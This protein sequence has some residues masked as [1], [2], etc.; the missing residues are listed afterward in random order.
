MN[1]IEQLFHSDSE[2]R[3]FARGYLAYLS[4]VLSRIDDVDEVP[5]CRRVPRRLGTDVETA[6]DGHGVDGD[7][8]VTLR[9]RPLPFVR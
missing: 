1:R 7:E 5:R 9:R 3:E 6:I 8:L 4:E 2:P